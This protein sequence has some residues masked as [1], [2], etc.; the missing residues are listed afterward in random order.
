MFEAHQY[1]KQ[2]IAHLAVW[3]AFCCVSAFC[4]DSRIREAN[5]LFEFEG[6]TAQANTLLQ[7][8][9]KGS[10]LEDQQTAYFYL[11]KIAD[12][13]GHPTDAALYLHRFLATNPD[14][15]EMTYWAAARLAVLDPR[16]VKLVRGTSLLPAAVLARIPGKQPAL[17]LSNHSLWHVSKNKLVRMST[18]IPADMRIMENGQASLWGYLTEEHRLIELNHPSG[19]IRTIIN[20]DSPLLNAFHLESGEWFVSTQKS[21]G[22]YRNGRAVWIHP[23]RMPNCAALAE[24]FTTRQILLNCPD[25]A[26][27]PLSIHDGQEKE[28]I[29]LLDRIDTILSSSEGIWVANTSSIWH[30][31]PHRSNQPIWQASFHSVQS[32]LLIENRLAILEADGSMNILDAL[33]GTLINRTRAEPGT[34]FPAGHRLGIFTKEGNVNFLDLQGQL[35]WRYQAGQAPSAEPILSDSSLFLPL[36]SGQVIILDAAYFGLSKSDI[37]VS[38]E[39]LE[40]IALDGRWDSAKIL[41]DSILSMEPGNALAWMQKA[42]YYSERNK[43][44]DSSLIAWSRA[45]R[46]SRSLGGPTQQQILKPYSRRLGALWIQYLPPSTQTYPKLFGDGHNLFTIDVGNRSL[47][48]LDPF[49]GLFRWKTPTQPLDQGFIAE[50]DGHYLIIGSGFDLSSHDLTQKGRVISSLG[51]PGK[52]FQATLTRNSVLVSTW[53]G[54]LIRF[55]KKGLEPIWSRKIF[56]TASFL[57]SNDS[58]IFA[59]SLDGELISIDAATGETQT[60]VQALNGTPTQLVATDTLLSVIGPEGLLMVHSQ[61]SLQK[62]WDLN[63][64]SQVFTAKSIESGVEN[65]SLILGLANQKLVLVDLSTRKKLWTYSGAGSIYVQPEIQ[66]DILLIDQDH[67]ILWLDLPTGT[68]IKETPIPNGAGP[69][70]STPATVYSTSPQGLLF[71]FPLIR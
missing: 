54:F 20:L 48:S 69:I 45:A 10:N 61:R 62:L 22:L 21:M 42:R 49:S 4:M 14:N 26:I 56:G 58:T 1:K 40:R 9:A 52:I 36:V 11:A 70:W 27:H 31:R 41:S 29:G 68:K 19:S 66:N 38:S 7:Q 17:Q 47:V 60:R 46:Y 64:N 5:F 30:F 55:N 25:N 23:N 57:A 71:A 24:S 35:L 2:R 37:R 13:S 8:V 32:L 43:N 6:N 67:S 53:N 28:S 15:S 33:T 44:A 59:L 65:P 3:L 63:L 18:P 12:W 51:L 50:N 34:L 39:R 16:P